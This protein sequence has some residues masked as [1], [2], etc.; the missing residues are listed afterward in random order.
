MFLN[1]NGKYGFAI[2]E[3]KNNRRVTMK[4]RE[5]IK[6]DPLALIRFYERALNPTI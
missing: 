4:R 2:L 6:R 5:V 1:E 3:K